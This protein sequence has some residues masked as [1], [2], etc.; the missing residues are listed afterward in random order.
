VILSDLQRRRFSPLEQFELGIIRDQALSLTAA[1]GKVDKQ[2]EAA[3]E[4]LGGYE[5]LASIKGIGP[6]SAAVPLTADGNVNDFENADRLAAYLGI[7][8]RVSRTNDT[9]KSGRITKRGDK[10]ARTTLV[11]RATSSG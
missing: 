3:A 9:D 4:N 8:P 7:V 5:G 6:R 11:H 1:L 2:V 10:L